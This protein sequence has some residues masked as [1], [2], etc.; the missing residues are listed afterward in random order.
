MP[1]PK[2]TL[3]SLREQASACR[4]RL[5]A[6]RARLERIHAEMREAE[7]RISSLIESE[8]GRAIGAVLRPVPGKGGRRPSGEDLASVLEQV[9]RTSG[10]PLG[11]PAIVI[12][13]RRA[14]YV[15]SSPSFP[16]IVGMRLGDGKRFRRV[17]R[18]VYTV[19]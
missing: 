1:E 19:A 15:T 8:G 17:G 16:R 3:A 11:I 13:A 10:K 5:D 6:L 2:T 18:G 12:A 4:G 14:G 7:R 9:L